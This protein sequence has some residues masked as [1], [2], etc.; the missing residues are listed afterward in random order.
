MP[1]SDA[2]S[3]VS[4]TAALA[5]QPATDV[6][7]EGKVQSAEVDSRY[8]TEMMDCVPH[9]SVSVPLIMHCMLEQVS[10]QG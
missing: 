7:A 1:V 2:Q 8:Y 3:A 5:A 10:I 6:L 9:E 4:V